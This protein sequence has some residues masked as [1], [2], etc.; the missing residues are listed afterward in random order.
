MTDY[1]ALMAE[2][3]GHIL[4]VREMAAETNDPRKRDA[5]WRVADVIEQKVRELDQIALRVGG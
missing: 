5:R 2:V 4:R 3:Q 1:I